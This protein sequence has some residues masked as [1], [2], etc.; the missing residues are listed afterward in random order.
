MKFHRRPVRGF[1]LVELLVVIAII[2]VLVG[3]LLPAVQ[4]AREAARRMSCS[5]NIRQI[6]MGA[7]NFE[8]ARK[9]MPG[10]YGDFVPSVGDILDEPPTAGIS[11]LSWMTSILPYVEQD[12]LYRSV[13]I[14]VDLMNDTRNVG[15]TVAPTINT[16]PWVAQQRIP[17]FRCP[18]D[19]TATPLADRGDRF[20][21]AQQYAT[22][23]YKGVS[24]SNWAW[25]VYATVPTDIF[26][27]DPFLLNQSN[28][29]AF[30][31][32]NGILFAGY[33]GFDPMRRSTPPS[34]AFTVPGRPCN[35]LLAAVK[36]GTSN[37]VLIGESVGNN[38][39]DNW[40]FWFKGCVATTAIPLNAPAQCPLGVGQ[41]PRKA[42][43]LCNADWPNNFGFSSDHSTGGNFALADGSVRYLSNE[44][45]LR[46]YRAMGAMQDGQVITIPD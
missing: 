34:A 17:L 7:I 37:T 26:H 28:G 10:N 25:G 42:L 20:T 3:L 8:S 6:A 29:N 38:T 19:T 32:G 9:Q 46:T 23:S 35:T 39:R 41:N 44:I 30:G 15:G 31:N 4:A 16:N 24:G 11:Q 14:S 2:G 18:S 1:T 40:W 27:L 36:D 43:E 22:T 5:N 45:D 33:K 21:N 13:V 12:N